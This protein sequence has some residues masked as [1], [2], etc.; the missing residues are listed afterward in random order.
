M[1]QAFEYLYFKSL[2]LTISGA[3]YP[4]VPHLGN[5]YDGTSVYVAKP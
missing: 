2:R 3:A 1:S 5:R 4:G